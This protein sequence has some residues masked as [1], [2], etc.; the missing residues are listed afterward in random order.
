LLELL[1]NAHLHLPSLRERGTD[2]EQIARH[3][4][5]D[6]ARPITAP[7]LTISTEAIHALRSHPWPGNVREL[8]NTVTRAAHVCEGGVIQRR[9][10]LFQRRRV[11]QDAGEVASVIQIPAEGKTLEAI[12][13]E[14][15]RVTL[16][17][18]HGNLSETARTLGISRP[19]LARKMC[20]AG[21]SK[22]SVLQVS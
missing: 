7:P 6:I 14:A 13:R 15:I 2:V 10:L 3:T 8:R 22:Q 18:T 17:L 9:H 4:L 1:R 16:I 11:L 19:T 12:A 21:L 5:A 20:E